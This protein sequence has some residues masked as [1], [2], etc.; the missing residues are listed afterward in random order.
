MILTFE[1][2]SKIK[3]KNCYKILNHS[4]VINKFS[5]TNII[6][7]LKTNVCKKRKRSSLILQLNLA[8]NRI[9]LI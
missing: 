1:K 5:I 9:S 3:C 7:H 4:I 8:F 2:Y 6:K